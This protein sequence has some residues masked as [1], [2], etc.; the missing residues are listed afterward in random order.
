MGTD[1]T[2]THRLAYDFSQY[3][4]IENM[5]SDGRAK[6]FVQDWMIYDYWQRADNPAIRIDAKYDHQNVRIEGGQLLLQQQGFSGG[7]HISMAGIQT[8]RLDSKTLANLC[9]L[10]FGL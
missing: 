1:T 7:T 9:R 2:Y 5:L 6:P 4:D 3:P 8:R 10:H